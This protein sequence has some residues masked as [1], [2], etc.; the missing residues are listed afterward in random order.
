MPTRRKAILCMALLLIGEVVWLAFARLVVPPI[1]T[2]AYHGDSLPFINRFF[3]ETPRHPITFYLHHWRAIADFGAFVWLGYGIFACL[4]TA[5]SFQRNVVGT[6]TPAAL[7][8]IRVLTCSILL[9][10]TLWEDLPSSAL[11]PRELIRPMGVLQLFY[12]LPIGFDHLVS[13]VAALRTFQWLTAIILGLGILGW[14]TRLV[15]PLGALGYLLL[16]GILRQY[17]WFYHT[18]L[19]PLYVLV[20]LSFT[21]CGDAYA[22]DR[23]RKIRQGKPVPPAYHATA[24]YGMARYACWIV[25]ALPYVAAGL[26][27]LRNGGFFWWEAANFRHILYRSVL[28]PMHFDFNGALALVTAPDT[29]VEAL[30]LV[31][32]LGELSYGLVLFSRPARRLLPALMMLMHLGILILQNILFFDLILLQLA[33]YDLPWHRR[34]SPA[35]V[36]AAAPPPPPRRPTAGLP[37]AL[38]GSILFVWLCGIEFY[39]FTAMQMFSARQPTTTITYEKALAHYASGAVGRAP[40]ETCL[41]ATADSRYRRVLRMAFDNAHPRVPAAFFHACARQW[42]RRAAAADRIVQFEVQQWQ[43]DFHAE[44]THPRFGHLIARRLYAP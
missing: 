7:G 17:A 10:S 2:Q 39:P 6:A 41:G 28:S 24:T 23:R 34:P 5:P 33:F 29:L 4:L 35:F 16:G 22:Y 3:A 44:P 13:S 21:P 32:L 30:A 1:I 9:M 18:G 11:L 31:G 27:K 25:I 19:V 14:H 8:A 42:N 20:V 15:V 43:W 26:S 38:S 12:V 37:L 40:L 36:P